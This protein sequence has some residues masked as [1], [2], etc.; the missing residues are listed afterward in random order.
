MYAPL[1]IEAN[2][3]IIGDIMMFEKTCETGKKLILIKSMVKFD[4][5]WMK[6][7]WISN[8]T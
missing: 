2:S 4:I 7:H 5:D 1:N 6:T 8:E 3:V